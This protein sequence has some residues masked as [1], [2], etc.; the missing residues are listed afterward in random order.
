MALNG[1]AA[2]IGNA[3]ILEP[4]FLGSFSHFI[5]CVVAVAGDGVTMKRAAQIFLLD[6]LRQGVLF[7]RFKLAAVLSQLRRHEIEI[8]RTIQIGFIPDSGNFADRFVLLR[9]RI[10]GQRGEPVF[11]QCPATLQRAAAHFDVVFL[12]PSE[13]CEGKR[14][15]RRRDNAQITLDSGSQPHAGFCR[16]LRDDG[17][18]Q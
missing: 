3:Q 9:L 8:D 14:I 18:D 2:V 16:T 11:V 4:K 1:T 5:E 17:L 15:F 13:I 6:E 7:S 12:V 10:D